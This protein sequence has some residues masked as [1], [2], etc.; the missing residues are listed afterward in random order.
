[1]ALTLDDLIGVCPDCSGTGKRSTQK[2]AGGGRSYGRQTI[3]YPLG[4]NE[5]DCP[6]CAGTGR[7]GLTDSGRAILE[8]MKAAGKLKERGLLGE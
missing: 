4:M 5:D 2:P 6:R 8:F 7:W 3:T 1:M